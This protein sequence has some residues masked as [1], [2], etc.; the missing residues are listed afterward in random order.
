MTTTIECKYV[1]P[2][3]IL[4]IKTSRELVSDHWENID[5]EMEMFC[6]C[7]GADYKKTTTEKTRLNARKGIT[8]YAGE[9]DRKSGSKNN[10][11]DTVKTKNGVLTIVTRIA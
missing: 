9:F 4:D 1:V 8:V 3:W 10:Q 2:R 5:S 6:A 11:T 7:C